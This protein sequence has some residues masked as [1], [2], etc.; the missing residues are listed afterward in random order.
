MSIALGSIFS[1]FGCCVLGGIL[2]LYTRNYALS[3]RKSK[4]KHQNHRTSVST[5][6]GVTVHRF[7]MHMFT[8]QNMPSHRQVA[9]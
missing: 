5:R 7:I 9:N 2:L 4:G 1:F 8:A 6:T 3:L